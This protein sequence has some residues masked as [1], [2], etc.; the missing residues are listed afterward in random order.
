MGW[1]RARPCWRIATSICSWTLA[2]RTA[3]CFILRSQTLPASYDLTDPLSEQ[4]ST[5]I[6]ADA[7]ASSNHDYTCAPH[8][9]LVNVTFS[10]TSHPSEEVL[11]F[12]DW[13]DHGSRSSTHHG[14]GQTVR[15]ARASISHQFYDSTN[16]DTDSTAA[17]NSNRVQGIQAPP[18]STEFRNGY[19]QTD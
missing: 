14:Q 18:E 11:G 9:R 4:D 15:A 3:R 10:C 16:L 6:G 8:S 12:Y 19:H 2:A 1:S 7:C 5:L 17:G 13:Q